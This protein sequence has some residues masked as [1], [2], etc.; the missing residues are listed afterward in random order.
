M[1][2]E[3]F[4]AGPAL[5]HGGAPVK[6][7]QV[8]PDVVVAVFVAVEAR[9]QV[10]FADRRQQQRHFVL[11]RDA[12]GTLVVE[13][14]RHEVG[15][16]AVEEGHLPTAPARQEDKAT[17]LLLDEAANQRHVR[18]LQ[19]AFAHTHVAEENHVVA[20]EL[21]LRAGKGG[22]IIAPAARPERGMEQHA[23]RLDARVAFEGVAEVA[24]FPARQRVHHEHLERLR[25]HGDAELLRVVVRERLVGLGRQAQRDGLLADVARRPHDGVLQLPAR[26]D[27][28]VLLNFLAVA[29]LNDEL[30]LHLA[31]QMA[32]DAERN[33]NLLPDEP[34]ARRGGAFQNQVRQRL[35]RAHAH[36]EDGCV[37]LAEPRGG[38]QRRLAGV[39]V[40]VRQHKHGAEVFVPLERRLQHGA[41]IRSGLG[42]HVEIRVRRRR[43]EVLDDDL[44]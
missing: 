16:R 23:M 38:E 17:A 9:E 18:L 33:G 32:R 24:V 35:L 31:R 44:A 6:A 8:F 40:T 30:R 43:G 4:A 41:Q 1:D 11:Q 29:R 39:P 26:R 19:L 15:E 14:H 22:E 34:V 5:L 7:G 10:A 28:D 27:G 12:V 37:R 2:G 25:A 20:L 13:L 42:L 21:L 3:H 36:G